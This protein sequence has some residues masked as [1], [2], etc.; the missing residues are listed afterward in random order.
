MLGVLHT[1]PLERYDFD[2]RGIAWE[3]WH[4]LKLDVM[5][6]YENIQFILLYEKEDIALGRPIES[7]I[8]FP[9]YHVLDNNTLSPYD[10][11]ALIATI[12]S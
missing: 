12:Q 5:V 3:P 10:L 7:Q 9:Y 4:S 6:L 2:F 8:V 1:N 11:L